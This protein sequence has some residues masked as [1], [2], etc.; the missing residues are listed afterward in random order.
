MGTRRIVWNESKPAP[1]FYHSDHIWDRI[2]VPAR[3]LD[4]SASEEERVP[5]EVCHICSAG[6]PVKE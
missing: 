2:T 3:L 1:E 6:R 4:K 5:Y